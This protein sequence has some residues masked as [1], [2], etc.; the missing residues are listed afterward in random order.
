MT[1]LVA[2]NPTRTGRLDMRTRKVAALA[3]LLAVVGAG[4]A[5]AY[6]VYFSWSGNDHTENSADA[7]KLWLC[8][9]ESDGH[10]V[11]TNYK[12][13][14]G[15]GYFEHLSG[16]GCTTNSSNSLLRCHQ[17]VENVPLARDDYGPM[18][19]PR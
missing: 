14:N 17:V 3:L 19:C 12:R 4:P 18:K 13:D 2:I 10:W 16:I 6:P 8:D 11:Y 7:K 1:P 15:W 9:G 5:A